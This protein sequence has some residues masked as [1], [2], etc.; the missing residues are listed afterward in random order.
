[1]DRPKIEIP[2][3]EIVRRFGGQ[4]ELARLVGL[5]KQAIGKWVRN[6]RIPD[7]WLKYLRLLRPGAF[8]APIQIIVTPER[9]VE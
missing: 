7:P 3:R 6:E 8:E 9:N 5:T 2:V 1:M 4:S